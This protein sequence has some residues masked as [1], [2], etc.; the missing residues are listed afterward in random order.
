MP[1]M[2]QRVLHQKHHATPHAHE[3][4]GGSESQRGGESDRL[5]IESPRKPSQCFAPTSQM[6]IEAHAKSQRS[7]LPWTQPSQQDQQDMPSLVKAPAQLALQR[8]QERCNMQS[9]H[10]LATEL[11]AALQQ[12]E[13][14]RNAARRGDIRSFFQRPVPGQKTRRTDQIIAVQDCGK[15]RC[16]V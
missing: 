15:D 8:E 4:P 13:T 3:L 1:A 16:R 12:Y 7:Q 11:H 14:K 10:P 5:P 9:D 2:P 6:M